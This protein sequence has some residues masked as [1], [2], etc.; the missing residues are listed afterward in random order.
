[1]KEAALPCG[2]EGFQTPGTPQ[3][4]GKGP[5]EQEGYLSVS[6]C[7]SL[8]ACLL[9]QH[10]LAL[11]SCLPFLACT[12]PPECLLKLFTQPGVCTQPNSRCW[13]QGG[14]LPQQP[15]LRL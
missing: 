9:L 14:V 12:G 1:M 3:A 5:Q 7:L 13:W 10:L 15:G 6:V 8:P 11:V 4:W 2:A